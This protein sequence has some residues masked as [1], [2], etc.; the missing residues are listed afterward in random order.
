M[1]EVLEDLVPFLA[2]LN[3]FA[4][5]LYT[6]SIMEDL[7]L[8]S[9]LRV[10]IGACV[11]STAVFWVFALTGEKLLEGVFRVEPTALR[12]FGGLIFLIVGYNYVTKGYRGAEVL[13]GSLEELPSAIALPFMIGAG[14]I[15][16]AIIVGKNHNWYMSMVILL[17]GVLVA[18]VT[19]IVFKLLRDH[20]TG[21]RERLFIR[22]VNI[23]ARLNGL[24]IGAISVKMIVEGLKG[25]W[26]V[27][28]TQPA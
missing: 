1:S 12:I 19:L 8:R 16:Q 17:M 14:T 28:P 22:Y 26:A 25:L 20:M 2:I 24:L 15:T 27:V 7:D 5:C 3:P 10:V 18:L 13:R 11:I 21:G 23:L 6:S 4:L 9:V